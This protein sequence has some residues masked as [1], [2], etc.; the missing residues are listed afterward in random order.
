[1]LAFTKEEEGQIINYN[2]NIT[3]GSDFDL[4]RLFAEPGI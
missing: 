1:M 2:N 4:I 3:L